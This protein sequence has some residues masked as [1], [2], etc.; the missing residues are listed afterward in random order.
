MD[1]FSAPFDYNAFDILPLSLSVPNTFL[2]NIPS[3]LK[4]TSF[5]KTEGDAMAQ[6]NLKNLFAKIDK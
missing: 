5:T 4:K 6:Q 2:T 3:K 1:A